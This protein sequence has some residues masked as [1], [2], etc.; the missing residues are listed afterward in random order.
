[1]LSIIKLGTVGSTAGRFILDTGHSTA[2]PQFWGVASLQTNFKVLEQFGI[3]IDGSG[4]L[5]VNTTDAPK[6]ESLTLKGIGPNGGDLTQ[7]FTLPSTSFAIQ[8]T[9]LLKFQ[10]PGTDTPLFKMTGGF[11]LEIDPPKFEIFATAS[12]EFGAGP[13]TLTYGKA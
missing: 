11:Y 8:I 6:T 12:L 10:P 7:T 5:Q 4:L 1:Q 13:A 9:A 3:F 2:V